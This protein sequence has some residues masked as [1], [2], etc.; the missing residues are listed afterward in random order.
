MT[1]CIFCRIARG[2]I[3]CHEVIREDGLLAFLDLGPIRPG[4]TLIVPE[5]HHDCFDEAPGELVSRIAL[6]GRRIARAQ[7]RMTGVERVAFM[8]SGGDVPH[9][10]AHIFPMVE[11][12]DIT[13]RR[14]IAEEVVTI[15]PIPRAD[16]S[17]LAATVRELR[18]SLTT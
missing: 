3:P 12:T 4:H 14:Y 8:F 10:H 6:L 9:V 1:T 5:E 18:A 7:K 13:S 15:R 2:E 11:K 17:D 16:D